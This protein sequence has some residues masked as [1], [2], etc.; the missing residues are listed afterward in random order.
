MKRFKLSSILLVLIFSVGC[1]S[2]F[3]MKT[4]TISIESNPQGADVYVVSFENGDEIFIGHTPIFN[5]E[6]LVPTKVSHVSKAHIKNLTA[7]LD[8]ARVIIR[9]R[10]FV[11]CTKNLATDQYVMIPHVI[12]LMP[13]FTCVEFD[14]TL[15]PK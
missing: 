2:N 9:K 6:V 3:G 4:R 7:Q 8:R 5:Q 10:G 12:D 13:I 14:T 11:S 1:Q 15:L